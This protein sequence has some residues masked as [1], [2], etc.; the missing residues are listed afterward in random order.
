M[1]DLPD[2]ASALARIAAFTSLIAACRASTFTA[3]LMLAR[4]AGAM[5]VLGSGDKL[6][7]VSIM[8]SPFMVGIRAREHR[9]CL[10]LANLTMKPQRD[11]TNTAALR[12]FVAP[13]CGCSAFVVVD[14]SGGAFLMEGRSTLPHPQK[15]LAAERAEV[16]R[17]LCGISM[18]VGPSRQANGASLPKMKAHLL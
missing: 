1:S 14:R 18:G 17:K 9:E 10:G 7:A 4:T 11:L 3:R 15:S 16:L 2:L 12:S 13:T 5:T 6:G 8:F